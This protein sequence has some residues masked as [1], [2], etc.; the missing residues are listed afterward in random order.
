MAL[1][2]NND[3]LIWDI[4]VLYYFVIAGPVVAAVVGVTMPRFCLYGHT[5]NIASKLES[6]SMRKYSAC[7][8]N[9]IIVEDLYQALERKCRA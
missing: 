4:A 1:I 5:V 6:T 7:K 2:T 3:L 8:R 9:A